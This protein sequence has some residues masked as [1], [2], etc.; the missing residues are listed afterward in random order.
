GATLLVAK[1][2]RL[3]RSVRF[4][5]ELRACGVPLA[6]ANIPDSNTLTFTVMSG[7]AQHERETISQRT[8]DALAIASE[9]R[10]AIWREAQANGYPPPVGLLGGLRAKSC[11]IRD[12]YKQGVKAN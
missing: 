5:A 9:R 6:A 2:D 3:S 4:L 7:L 12:Y 1:L 11:V 8:K 10:R